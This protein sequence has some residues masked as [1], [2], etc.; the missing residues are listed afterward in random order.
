VI[1]FV[2]RYD[3]TMLVTMVTSIV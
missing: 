2:A 3:Y 1:L